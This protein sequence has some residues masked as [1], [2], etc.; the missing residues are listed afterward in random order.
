MITD[1]SYP[2]TNLNKAN[3][4]KND[5]FYTKLHD[6]EKELVHYTEYFE[7]K[8]IYCNC[9]DP[10]LSNFFVYFS[11]NFEKL[12]LK[13]LITT[14]Y[15]TKQ[16]DLFGENTIMPAICSI[17]YGPEKTVQYNLQG[18]G[19]FRSEEC[20]EILKQADI[21]VTNPPFSLFK[22]YIC[23]INEV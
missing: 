8:I 18:D 2:N 7:G 5:E 9:D 1:M 14:C 15:K 19:D 23:T 3:K 6:I 21:I 10:A 22:E 16:Q 17:T 11:E 13:K 12:K 4:V 20:I